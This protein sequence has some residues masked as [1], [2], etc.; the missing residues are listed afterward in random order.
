M[1]TLSPKNVSSNPEKFGKGS[2]EGIIASEAANNATVGG[3][4]IPLIAMGIPGSVIDAI[5]IGA[6]TIHSI[7]PGPTLFLTNSDI[8]WAMIATALLANILM[9]L[10]MTSSVRYISNLI[11]LPRSFVLPV[12]MMF[13]VIGSYALNNTMF[14]VWVMLLFGVIGFLL[15]RARIPLGPFVIGFVLAPLGEEKLRSGLMMTA[16]DISPIF[17]RPLSPSFYNHGSV[18]ADLATIQRIQAAAQINLEGEPMKT[19]LLL[20]DSLPLK[21]LSCYGGSHPTPNFDRLAA[22]SLKFNRH[23]VG[24]LPCM[25]ARRDLQTG[26][27]NFLHRSWGPLEP[28]DISATGLMR[29][30]GIY[31]H[32]VTDHYHYFENGGATYHTAFD[33]WD[34]IRG[35]EAD[36]WAVAISPPS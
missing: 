13:C 26:R 30:A 31:S 35:Q 28:F 19:T 32:L 1:H 29:K 5:L 36:P 24:S 25:P 14:D 9:W 4:L 12:V 33:S 2:E 20:F 7:Q 23:F 6:L 34:F 22:Q 27:L 21:S 10:L 18:F 3:A 17:T 15:E 8:V 11:Y 16:G